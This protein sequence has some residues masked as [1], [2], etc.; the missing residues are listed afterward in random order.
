MI[1]D[2]LIEM[3]SFINTEIILPE[4]VTEIIH[5]RTVGGILNLLFIGFRSLKT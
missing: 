5:P 1:V 4:F 3:Y 2:I